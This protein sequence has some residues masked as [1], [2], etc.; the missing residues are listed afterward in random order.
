MMRVVDVP[1]EARPQQRRDGRRSPRGPRGGNLDEVRE[2]GLA[3]VS[4]LL[5][6]PHDERDYH[7]LTKANLEKMYVLVTDE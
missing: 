6:T 5:N 1:A 2:E 7:T 3:I 4:D